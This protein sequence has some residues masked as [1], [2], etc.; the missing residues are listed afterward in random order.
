MF[1]IEVLNTFWDNYA[2]L[3][4]TISLLASIATFIAAILFKSKIREHLRKND[5]Q[6]QRNKITKELQGYANN[7]SEKEVTEHL[8]MKLG[9]RLSTLSD[10]YPFFSIKTK[11]QIRQLVRKL[12]HIPADGIDNL[13]GSEYHRLFSD[14]S[15]VANRIGKE[16]CL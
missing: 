8:L 11:W 5:F 1:M 13:K 6:Q 7:I 16:D 4:N 15:K 3:L 14:V 12:R 2:G 10:Q 9:G